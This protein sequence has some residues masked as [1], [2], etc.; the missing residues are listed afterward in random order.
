MTFTRIAP[1]VMQINHI[2]VTN[3]ERLDQDHLPP[4][5]EHRDKYVRVGAQTSNP[6]HR[7]RPFY[8]KSYLDSLFAGYSEPLLGLGVTGRRSST[9]LPQGMCTRLYTWT[10]SRKVEDYCRRMGL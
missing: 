2:R 3:M 4:L 1:T 8:L 9:G 5:G 7:R 6:L 10:L